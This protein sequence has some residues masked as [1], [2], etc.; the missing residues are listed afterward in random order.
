MTIDKNNVLNFKIRNFGPIKG[1]N[2]EIKHLTVFT[3]PNN[4]GKS[5]ASLLVHSLTSH[6][7]STIVKDFPFSNQDH[8][9]LYNLIELFIK[10]VLE[11]INLFRGCLIINF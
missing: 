3:G 6:N 2:L 8:E 5:Y 1:A 7:I 9:E 11:E 4:S 10:N